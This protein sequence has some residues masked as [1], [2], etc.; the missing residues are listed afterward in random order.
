MC[1]TSDLQDASREE[2]WTACLALRRMVACCRIER[3]S[4][5]AARG[6]HDLVSND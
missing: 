5:T 2:V 4:K 3:T 6:S 1:D